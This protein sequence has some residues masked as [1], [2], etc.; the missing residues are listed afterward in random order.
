MK[1]VQEKKCECRIRGVVEMHDVRKT[2]YYNIH[3]DNFMRR[4]RKFKFCPIC[5]KELP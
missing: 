3:P 5:G 2:V 1:K 4:L